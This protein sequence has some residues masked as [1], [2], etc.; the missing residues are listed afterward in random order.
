MNQLNITIGPV[1]GY[2]AQA[3][4]T[5]DLWS[6]SFLLSYLSGCAIYGATKAGG[7]IKEPNIEGDHLF[8]LITLIKERGKDEVNI[9][10]TGLIGSLPNRITIECEEPVAVVESAKD[11]FYRSWHEISDLVWDEFV[12]NSQEYGYNSKDIW[13]RQVASFWEFSWTIG[14]ISTIEKRKNWRSQDRP[15]EGGDHCTIMSDYQEI[16]GYIRFG[17]KKKQNEFWNQIRKGV[18]E[19]DLKKDE[20]LC[21]ISF[22]KRFFPRISYKV[23]G[24]DLSSDHWPSTVYMAAVPWLKNLENNHDEY[25]D[26]VKNA[27]RN[28]I[29]Y[30]IPKL[31]DL[32][33]RGKLA[34][35]DGNFFYTNMI[36]SSKST[37]IDK[38]EQRSGI[39]ESLKRIYNI[40]GGKPAP[41]YVLL[42]M[43]GDSLGKMKSNNIDKIE[44]ISNALSNFSK[45]VPEI[46]RN[47]NG[48]TI[49]A[50]G[51]DV[52]AMLPM[53]TALE[54]ASE[55]KKK[56][57][58]SFSGVELEGKV[59]ISA[60]LV[61][62]HYHQPLQSIMEMSNFL[63]DDIAKEKNGRDSIAISVIK[64]S[65]EYIRCVHKWG[66]EASIVDKI[67]DS[68][69]RFQSEGLLSSS[70]MY[71]VRDSF[72]LLGD[73]HN[74][75]PGDDMIFVSDMDLD[76]EKLLTAEIIR[77]KEGS[78][79]SD[80][81][82]KTIKPIVDLCEK[83]DNLFSIDSWF[84]IHFLASNTKGVKK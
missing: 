84:L 77:S 72:S 82:S 3:R 17:Y 55:L 24:V 2:V 35:L 25:F 61:Y 54:C 22:V 40:E 42:K 75:K 53:N 56:Y 46:I 34:F 15:D 52:L 79:N 19:L 11:E 78:V 5:R 81:I 43:D 27:K 74:W 39:V 20:R 65:G 1:Q 76:I 48:V 66:K 23:I 51:D 67:T 68:V 37:P 16:S 8:S 36:E 13:D 33:G 69:A 83:G 44:D 63:L 60:G 30:D 50:G 45:N 10:P 59:S 12:K 18:R 9:D 58:D 14:D 28:A 32:E 71:S 38:D 62:S 70:F 4:R 49:Y 73:I 26:I 80:E 64:G 21:A 57:V 31:V 47:H 29:R 7:K 6:G 41:Y